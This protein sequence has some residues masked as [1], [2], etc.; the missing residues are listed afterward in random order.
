MATSVKLADN[1]VESARQQAKA[2]HRTLGGQV[3]YWAMIG[4]I[5]EQHPHLNF[6]ALQTLLRE[7][8]L[9]EA[10]NSS[11]PKR[12]DAIKLDTRDFTFD[13]DEANAR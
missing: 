11:T 12:F 4:R 1:T 6:A 9:Q 3:D 7:N 13:R 2:F 10:G 8:R 5:A